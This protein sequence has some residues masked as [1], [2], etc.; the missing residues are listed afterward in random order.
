MNPY[1]IA[2]NVHIYKRRQLKKN[3]DDII[4]TT[5]FKSEF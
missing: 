2:I 3:I 4:E 1:I 5:T